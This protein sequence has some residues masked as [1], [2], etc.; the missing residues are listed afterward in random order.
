LDQL[1]AQ[2]GDGLAALRSQHLHLA[3]PVATQ[4][5]DDVRAAVN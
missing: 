3:R 1:G 4:L 5:G 2:I